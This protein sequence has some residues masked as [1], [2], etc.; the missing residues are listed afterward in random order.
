MEIKIPGVQ[1]APSDSMPA[2]TTSARP[3]KAKTKR[4]PQK[5]TSAP[6]KAA[7]KRPTPE[8]PARKEP[9]DKP[10]PP[11]RAD[12]MPAP[13]NVPAEPSSEFPKSILIEDVWL[14]KSGLKSGESPGGVLDD[15]VAGR[16]ATFSTLVGGPTQL[17]G[18]I[19]IEPGQGSFSRFLSGHKFEFY[20]IKR[21]DIIEPAPHSKPTLELT[22]IL[23][24]DLN[25]AIRSGPKPRK[26][27]VL[28]D[29][30]ILVCRSGHPLQTLATEKVTFLY[31]SDSEPLHG[32]VWLQDRQLHHDKLALGDTP[33]ADRSARV[34]ELL[35]E[36]R[37]DIVRGLRANN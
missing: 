30:W 21:G 33:L 32:R 10:R 25:K 14:L 1:N 7:A 23:S 4:P 17:H 15:L 36:L 27:M 26:R 6:Q 29:K 11:T 31:M 16:P 24:Q 9:V 35:H 28:E 13:S 5:K 18:I 22:R 20:R 19:R 3:P 34:E 8:P 37:K 2:K 12:P